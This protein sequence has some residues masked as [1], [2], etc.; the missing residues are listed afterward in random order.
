MIVQNP[1]QV[2]EFLEKWIPGAQYLSHTYGTGGYCEYC[3][4]EW[5]YPIQETTLEL[6][7]IVHR[8]R[9][10]HKYV[11]V[12]KDRETCENR[13]DARVFQEAVRSETTGS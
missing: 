4:A 6:C 3:H 11:Q 8:W 5:Q 9:N 12:C 13:R 2:A 7:I 10:A 1:Q